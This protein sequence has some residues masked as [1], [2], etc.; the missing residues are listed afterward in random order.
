MKKMKDRIIVGAVFV[1]C[2]L[3]LSCGTTSA[4]DKNDNKALPINQNNVSIEEPVEIPG[5]VFDDWEYKGF[6]YELADW[7]IP[8]YTELSDEEGHI[9]LIDYGINSDMS[10]A[11][12]NDKAAA[13][14]KPLELIKKTWVRIADKKDNPYCSIRI[15]AVIEAAET[16]PSDLSAA[17]VTE[18]IN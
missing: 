4:A 12:V 11:R 6:G 1:F 14:G 3:F 9:V 5:P 8:A 2:S 18:T 10:E 13:Y 15:Y 17:A 16:E 7:I